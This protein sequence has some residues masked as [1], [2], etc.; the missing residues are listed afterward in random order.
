MSH[1]ALIDCGYWPIYII[2]RVGER[3]APPL[4]C[5]HLSFCLCKNSVL[6][7]ACSPPKGE[8]STPNPK[9]AG[10]DKSEKHRQRGCVE[11][12]NVAM[13]MRK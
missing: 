13:E 12:L 11:H 8:P 5:E 1:G 7:C 10:E 6:S 4:E 2:G 9:V 3:L